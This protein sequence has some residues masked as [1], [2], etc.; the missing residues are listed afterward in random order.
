[1]GSIKRSR[2]RGEAT[3]QQVK[4]QRSTLRRIIRQS[5]MKIWQDFLGSATIQQVWQALRY[6]KPGGQQITKTLRSRRGEVA[7]SWEDKVKLI[8]EEAFPKPLEGVRWKAPD[9]GGEMRKRITEE[10]I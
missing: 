7:E 5:K 1:L 2:K 9:K 8:Q 3:Q 4:K 10:N 6:T